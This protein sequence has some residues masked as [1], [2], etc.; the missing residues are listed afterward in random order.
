MQNNHVYEDLVEYFRSEVS[1]NLRSQVNVQ[2]AST[3]S[4]IAYLL[5]ANLRD[6]T[7]P[8]FHLPSTYN[9]LRIPSQ[10]AES[11]SIPKRVEQPS[12][13]PPCT[14]VDPIMVL[15]Y[16]KKYE[17]DINPETW[18]KDI[19]DFANA[20]QQDLNGFLLYRMA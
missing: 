15:T 3:I 11:R 6:S 9:T 20:E 12:Q 1:L 16:P 18:N 17:K 2:N 10:T 7:K 5:T 8:K 19:I 4:Q 13:Y 14:F